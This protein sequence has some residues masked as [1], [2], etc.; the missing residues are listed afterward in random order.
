ML[1]LI[2]CL[3][4]EQHGRD[5]PALRSSLLALQS[6]VLLGGAEFVASRAQA[7]AECLDRSVGRFKEA[8]AFTALD[9][10]DVC[11]QLFPQLAPLLAGPFSRVASDAITLT[12][13]DLF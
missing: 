12:V 9:V 11:V 6:Y 5:Q 1:C 10:L 7:V 13:R 2:F 4:S 8:L 3:R